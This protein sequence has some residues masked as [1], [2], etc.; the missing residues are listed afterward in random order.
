MGQDPGPQKRPL[1]LPLLP[2]PLLRCSAERRSFFRSSWCSCSASCCFLCCTDCKTH[3]RITLHHLYVLHVATWLECRVPL[4]LVKAFKRVTWDSRRFLPIKRFC[5][6]IVL[7]PC[8]QW[9]HFR[10]ISTSKFTFWSVKVSCLLPTA[11]SAMLLVPECSSNFNRSSNEALQRHKVKIF[12]N[13]DYDRHYNW[14]KC[15]NQFPRGRNCHIMNSYN[16]WS[17]MIYL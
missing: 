13:V 5:V 8:K 2:R 11:L 9:V 15:A 1:P 4:W 6:K 14:L 10:L 17:N 16:P 12:S 3:R 7:P